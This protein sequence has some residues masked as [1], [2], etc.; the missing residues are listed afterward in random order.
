MTERQDGGVQ[1]TRIALRVALT[2]VLLFLVLRHTPPGD[3]AFALGSAAPHLL[4]AAAGLGALFTLLKVRRWEWLL[5][6]LGLECTEGEALHSYLGG[7]ALGLTTPGRLGEVGRSLYFAGGDR[8]FVTGAALL[9][10]VFDVSI[11]FAAGA[12]GCAANGLAIPAACLWVAAL[13][14]ASFLALPA[15]GLAAVTRLVPSPF[16]RRIA[17][18]LAEPLTKLD[19]RTLVGAYAQSAAAFATTVLQFHV[20]LCAFGPAPPGVT[21]FVL[22]LLILSNLVP[23]TIS[24]VGVRE[25]ASVLLFSRYGIDAAVAVS[26][27]WLLYAC[28]S[29]LPGLAG[30]L[31][32]PQWGGG[33]AR[34]EAG[35][36]L[37]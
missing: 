18:R 27:A 30:A 5:R 12:A 34:H 21:L 23:I 24:G 36:A 35:E 25:W 11:V 13:G 16:A 22:P 28:N 14:L 37:R 4:L 7:M 32:A 19:R 17:E 3:I 20:C 31:L 33:A 26:V 1:G 2:A 10:K 6:R 29:F 15:S 8:T 9:D